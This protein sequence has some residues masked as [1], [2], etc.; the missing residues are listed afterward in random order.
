MYDYIGVGAIYLRKR[1]S[2]EA[3]RLIGNCSTLSFA[4]TN[5]MP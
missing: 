2:A 5:T 3:A 4:I 1:D